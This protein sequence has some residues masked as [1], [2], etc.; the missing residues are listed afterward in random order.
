MRAFFLRIFKNYDWFLLSST[1]FLCAMGLAVL[2]SNTYNFNMDSEAIRQSI[3][4]AIGIISMFFLSQM[5]YRIFRSYSGILYIIT[6]AMLGGV[7]IFGKVA[8][9]AQRWIDLGFFQLQPS[10]LAQLLMVIIMAKFFSERYEEMHKPKTILLSG[11]YM[12]VPT[13]LV[14]AQPNLGTAIVFAFVWAVMLLV[15]NA[16][17]IHIWALGAMGAAAVPVVWLN[18]KAYQKQRVLTFLNPASDPMGAGWNVKQAIIAIG[19]GQFWGRGL[20][21]GTQSQLNFIPY[22]HTDFIFAALGEEMGF[23]GVGILLLLFMLFFYRGIRTAM[24]AR[25]FFGTY[26]AIGILAILFIHVFVN[27]GMNMGIMPVTG[28]PLPFVSYGGTPA[29]VF[30]AAV[31][32]LESI[33]ARY[34]KI[35]F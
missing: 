18:M 35:D 15:S 22:K 20:G 6:V 3:F 5:D 11:A 33:Y 23:L 4:M 26:L 25:D 13:L 28:I 31:G 19:S 16:K 12:A 10:I 2:F 17:R 7:L 21:R 30:L 8:N 27:I 32:I 29:L 34:K 24:L 14:A 9:N 1:L